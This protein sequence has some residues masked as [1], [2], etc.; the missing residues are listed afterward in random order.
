MSP[1]A[2]ICQTVKWEFYLAPIIKPLSGL[3]AENDIYIFS[4]DFSQY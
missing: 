3:W 2:N 4:F 1:H